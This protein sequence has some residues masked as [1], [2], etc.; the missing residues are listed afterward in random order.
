MFQLTPAG[1]ETVLY[2]FAN[3][4]GFYPPGP[5]PDTNL[6]QGSDGNFCSA[7]NYGGAYN[8]GYFFG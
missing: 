1:V 7:T 8:R 5:S 6:V 2:S 4:S 3:S